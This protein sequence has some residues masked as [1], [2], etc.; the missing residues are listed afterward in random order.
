MEM[1]SD[2][3][4]LFGV[5]AN[6]QKWTVLSVSYLFAMYGGAFSC[7][8]LDLETR[9]IFEYFSGNDFS[10]NLHLEDGRK[11]WFKSEELCSLILNV[12][13]MLEK[14]PCGTILEK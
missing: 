8:Q 1:H 9:K 10:A 13:L 4:L 7:L 2:Q 6:E 5:Y 3:Q 12:M 11:I 14:V